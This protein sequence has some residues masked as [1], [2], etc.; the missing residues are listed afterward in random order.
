M[1]HTW[2]KHKESGGYWQAPEAVVEAF[3]ARGWEPCDPPEQDDSYLYDQKPPAAPEPQPR[4]AA[5]GRTTE[6]E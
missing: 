4:K 1:S 6:K 2:L 3:E 5:R